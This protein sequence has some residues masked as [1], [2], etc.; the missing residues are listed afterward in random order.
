MEIRMG[1]WE[2]KETGQKRWNEKL[3]NEG[4]RIQK[5]QIKMSGNNV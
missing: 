2:I 3:G 5:R 4:D 1:N